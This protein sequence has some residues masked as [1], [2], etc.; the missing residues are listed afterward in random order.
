MMQDLPDDC[1]REILLRMTDHRDIVATGATESRTKDLSE[2]L[3]LWRGLC[4]FHFDNIQI[5]QLLKGNTQNLD[6][7]TTEDWKRLYQR[8]M[9]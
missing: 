5:N 8:L 9:K 1:I 2:E 7:Y 4:L 3:A 6:T